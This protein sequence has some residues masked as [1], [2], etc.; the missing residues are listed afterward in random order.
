[1]TE[2]HYADNQGEKWAAYKAEWSK[3]WASLEP[4]ERAK[5][6]RCGVDEPEQDRIRLNQ[7]GDSDP[8]TFATDEV[9]QSVPEEPREGAHFDA[10]LA[11]LTSCLGSSNPLLYLAC[12]GNV[13]GISPFGDMSLEELGR[14]AGENSRGGQALSKQ[15]AQKQRDEIKE[16]YGLRQIGGK[17]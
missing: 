12:I 10:L 6:Q 2:E 16:T 7:R 15:R 4:E 11:V 13:V 5:F 9:L 8:D 1:M 14:W 3:F 17:E